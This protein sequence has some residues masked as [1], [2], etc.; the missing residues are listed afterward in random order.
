[1]VTAETLTPAELAVVK[2][3]AQGM[4]NKEIGHELFCSEHTVRAHI[5]TACIRLDKRSRVDLAVWFER[6][7]GTRHLAF[8]CGRCQKPFPHTFALLEHINLAHTGEK[9]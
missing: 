2:L 5:R 8:T 3:V 1:M 7:Y 6:L 4:T 9:A